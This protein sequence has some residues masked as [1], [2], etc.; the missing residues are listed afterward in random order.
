M[1]RSE[2]TELHYITPVSNVPSIMQVGILSHDRA[3]QK[4]HESVAMP[5]MQGRRA[6]LVVPGGRRL[7]EYANLYICARNPMLYTRRSRHDI[8]VLSI[9][10]DV[11][12][13]SGVIVTN[14]NAGGEYA[15]WA[16]APA[17]LKIVDKERTFAENWTDGDAITYWRK[18][19]AK[20]AEVLVPDRV[21]PEYIS[22]AY[23]PD[24]KAELNFAALAISL[25]V[26][27][28]AHMFFM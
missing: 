24:E 5:Q 25:Q 26:E 8:C 2:L 3:E 11:L 14:S 13:L 22:K 23:V 10:L 16:P 1:L 21:L 18:K 28:N 20:C 7:H 4:E 15:R 17:G 27:I 12:D 6:N 19:A 9:C